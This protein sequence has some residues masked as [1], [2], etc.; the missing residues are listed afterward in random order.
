MG[1][2]IYFI[3]SAVLPGVYLSPC[4]YINWHIFQPGFNTDK[5]GNLATHSSMECVF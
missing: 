2:G 3:N 5:Y 1:P 4:M